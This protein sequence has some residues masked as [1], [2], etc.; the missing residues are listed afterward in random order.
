MAAS[1]TPDP[2]LFN[3]QGAGDF[4]IS[5]NVVDGANANRTVGLAMNGSGFAVL[6]GTNTYTAPTNVTAGTL[7]VNGDNSAATGLITLTNNAVLG[8]TGTIGGAITVGAAATLAPGVSAGTLTTS[9]NVGGDGTLAIEL[10]GAAADKLV[11]TGTGVIDISAL[12]LDVSTLVGGATSPAYVIVDSASAITGGAF[13]SVTGVPSGYNLVY[14]YND[15]SDSNNIALVSGTP[16]DPFDTW[17]TTTQGLAGV[18][19]EPGA[20]PD[21]D[22]LDNAIEFVLGGQ[23]NPA[24]P[25]AASNGL[26]PTLNAS[27]ANLVFTYRRTDLALTQ[28]GIGIKVEHGSNLIGWTAAVDGEAGVTVAVTDDFYG[29]GVDRVEVSIPKSGAKM[30]ARLNVQI[31]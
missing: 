14:N 17:A 13:A 1:G 29:A 8:G 24:N 27:G 18:D 9:A 10:D 19:A 23:P 30:F 4:L 12:K 16:S 6:T 20:D 22:G 25:N 11:V 15:G 5:G 26:V 28:P 31:P 7:L 3:L 21:N 2:R